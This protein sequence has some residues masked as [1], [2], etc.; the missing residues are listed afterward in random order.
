[1]TEL[2]IKCKHSEANHPFYDGVGKIKCEKFE[3]IVIDSFAKAMKYDPKEE[4]QKDIEIINEQDEIISN[5]KKRIKKSKQK[6]LELIDEKIKE[7]NIEASKV[8]G[9]DRIRLFS[10]D[11]TY[12]HLHKKDVE[13]LKSAITGSK[14]NNG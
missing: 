4:L 10:E 7:M 1:M 8:H 13:E 14:A 5:L 6:V 2:C 11:R 12:L 3:P 9:D